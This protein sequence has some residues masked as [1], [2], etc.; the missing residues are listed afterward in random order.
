MG[1]GQ[2]TESLNRTKRFKK[3]KFALCLNWD[4]CLLLFLVTDASGSWA[5]GLGLTSLPPTPT[6][7]DSQTFG[8]GLNYTTIITDVH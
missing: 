8:P 3:G 7:P 1:F 4:V 6:S 2:S 5:F